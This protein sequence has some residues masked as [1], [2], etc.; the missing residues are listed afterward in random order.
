[1]LCKSRNDP[2]T[3][4]ALWQDDRSLSG[5]KVWKGNTRRPRH[6]YLSQSGDIFRCT[7]VAA[8]NRVSTASEKSTSQRLLFGRFRKFQSN[9]ASKS[10]KD[11]E[12]SFSLKRSTL[13]CICVPVADI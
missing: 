5:N 3:T 12:T 10:K 8:V 9:T 1:M 13:V 6:T 11:Y 7:V 4:S 2:T